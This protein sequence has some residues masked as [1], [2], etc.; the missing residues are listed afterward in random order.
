MGH[1]QR[2]RVYVVS[3]RRAKNETAEECDARLVAMLNPAPG[4]PIVTVKVFEPETDEFHELV[5]YDGEVRR[6]SGQPRIPPS[7]QQARPS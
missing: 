5:F 3:M 4:N 2:R 6:S 7:A 1:D